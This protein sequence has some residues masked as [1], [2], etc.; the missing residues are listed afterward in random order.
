MD[1]V[2]KI[3]PLQSVNCAQSPLIAFVTRANIETITDKTIN[4]TIELKIKLKSKGIPG[5]K[6]D[7]YRLE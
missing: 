1:K 3:F 5:P 2:L 7:N 6:K 4:I